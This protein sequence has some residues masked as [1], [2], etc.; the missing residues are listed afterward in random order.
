MR[1]WWRA[2]SVVLAGVLVAAGLPLL[3]QPAA[4]TEWTPGDAWD[5]GTTNVPVGGRPFSGQMRV[6]PASD[7]M[8]NRRLYAFVDA[9]G[10]LEVRMLAVPRTVAMATGDATIRVTS[11]EGQVFYAQQAFD[12]LA[13]SV[14]GPD[15]IRE[16]ILGVDEPLTADIAGVWTIDMFDA[17]TELAAGQHHVSA[18]RWD[19][20]P[21]D[22]DGTAHQGRVW[23]YEYHRSAYMIH[24]NDYLGDTATLFDGILDVP[25]G[26]RPNLAMWDQ[27]AWIWSAD[28]LL[29]R[30]DDMGYNGLGSVLWATSHGLV[31][32]DCQPLR[33]SIARAIDS[34]LSDTVGRCGLPLYRVFFEHPDLT[35]PDFAQ[36]PD[37]STQRINFPLT[38]PSIDSVS[39][40]QTGTGSVFAGQIAVTLTGQPTTVRV[41]IDTD[42]DGSFDGAGDRVLFEEWTLQPGTTNLPWN[43]LDANGVPV[44]LDQT[45]GIRVTPLSSFETHIVAHDVERR[46]GGIRLTALNGPLADSDETRYLVNWD[47]SDPSF[48]DADGGF[49]CWGNSLVPEPCRDTDIFPESIVGTRVDSRDGVHRW[50]GTPPSVADMTAAMA[51]DPDLGWGVASHTTASWGDARD[52][53]TW[54]VAD[55]SEEAVTV[56]ISETPFEAD[57]EITIVVPEDEDGQL[58]LPVCPPAEDVRLLVTVT[59]HGPD[60]ATEVTVTLPEGTVL[61]EDQ[62]HVTVNEGGDLVLVGDLEVDEY[63]TFYVI[64]ELSEDCA[65]DVTVV[66]E[67]AEYDPNLDNNEDT[68]TGVTPGPEA[69]LEIE[70]EV[71][72][73]EDGNLVLP[74]C[75]PAGETELLVT[76]TNHGPYIGTDVTVT[77][78]AGT[79]LADG[80]DHVTV[81]EG[82]YLV[83][84]G[85]LEVDEYVTFYVISPLSEDCAWDVTVSVEGRGYDPNLDNNEDTTTGVT[86]GPPAD[87]DIDID[88][89][90]D[91]DGEPIVPICPPAGDIELLVTVTNHGPYIGTDV[92]VT[93]P[94]GTVLA[95]GQDHVTVNEGGYLVFL[96]DLE[97]DDQVTFYVI[98]P[99]SEDCAWDVTVS[100]EGRGE[101]PNLDNNEDTS[102]GDPGTFPGLGG[103]EETPGTGNG[104]NGGDGTDGDGPANGGNLGGGQDT[105]A[106]GTPGSPGAPNG[107]GVGGPG[108]PGGGAG[109]GVGSG[110]RAPGRLPLTGASG[111][112]IAGAGLAV[113]G[114]LLLA[115]NNRKSKAATA[116]NE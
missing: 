5:L 45:I 80:Q 101:D 79:V 66:V 26:A 9:G 72:V 29:V 90:V 86:D 20:V 68:T 55:L 111:I 89:P 67:G 18:L 25:S 2:L 110:V 112:W 113:V 17:T 14:H 63:V 88:V 48:F 53:V 91:E 64:S 30:V 69:D 35:M 38:L 103:G 3:V 83:F 92:T 47:D 59:N 40:S 81:N 108:G 33:R 76:V 62:D 22:A 39:Y 93:L 84:L 56:I 115:L 10:S 23:T 42:G 46:L 97:V 98:S 4:A 15:A 104:N 73:D 7:D 60:D 28:G 1:R 37:G 74:I 49:L 116:G 99:L 32:E 44:P 6:R 78:P 82:G 95:P 65:W 58:V 96:G 75:P 36:F 52:I 106:A 100:V 16:V 8:S 105:P 109:S 51:A 41:E 13:E 24:L 50:G 61:A 71:P 27:S 19:I 31:D 21:R 107:P 87:L 34:A 94:A 43:G 102:T 57:L 85:D 114:G 12:G 77:L 11:P 70:I 54:Q